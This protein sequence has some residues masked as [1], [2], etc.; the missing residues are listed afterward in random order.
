MEL[1]VYDL[2]CD[3]QQDFHTKMMTKVATS[4]RYTAF[5]FEKSMM[6]A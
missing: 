6:L 3:K 2:R 5:I 4:C 1:Q